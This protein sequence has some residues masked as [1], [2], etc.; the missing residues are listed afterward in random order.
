MNA[1]EFFVERFV[2][3]SPDVLPYINPYNVNRYTKYRLNKVVFKTNNIARTLWRTMGIEEKR[4]FRS[5][6]TQWLAPVNND[7]ET[8]VAIKPVLEYTRKQHRSKRDGKK[9]DRC[10]TYPIYESSADKDIVGAYSKVTN[11]I[12]E[13]YCKATVRRAFGTLINSEIYLV[14]WNDIPSN[15][16]CNIGSDELHIA[17]HI[18]TG[19]WVRVIRTY[20]KKAVHI[21]HAYICEVSHIYTE[22]SEFHDYK[23]LAAHIVMCGLGKLKLLEMD[24]SFIHGL[25]ESGKYF[26]MWD[27]YIKTFGRR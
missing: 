14:F 26:P 5:Q 1:E 7:I 20:F 27:I 3:R 23:N 15:V 10:R 22:Y 24:T 8:P 25:I 6:Y 4:F 19:I 18:F 13:I 12:S 11:P 2:S 17:L 9:N 21:V 16:Y